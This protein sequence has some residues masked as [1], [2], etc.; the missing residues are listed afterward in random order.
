[1]AAVATAEEQNPHV[2]NGL[3]MER[4]PQEEPEAAFDIGRQLWEPPETPQTVP[5]IDTCPRQPSTHTAP[6]DDGATALRDR[7]IAEYEARLQNSQA[8]A[9]AVHDAGCRGP[10]PTAA[11]G[12]GLLRGARHGYLLHRD[13]VSRSSRLAAD[14]TDSPW[15]RHQQ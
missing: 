14:M 12:A 10:E 3:S 5:N 11:M 7:R 1:M 15:A 9:T 8:R 6:T 13:R 4:E 2:P